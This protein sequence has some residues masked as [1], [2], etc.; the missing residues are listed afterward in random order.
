MNN[1]TKYRA[2]PECCVDPMC[3]S[4]LRNNYFEGKRL[5]V[6]SFRVEQKYLLERRQLLNRAI[7]GWG[8][9]YGFAI[10]AGSPDKDPGPG[11]LKIGAGLAL[12]QCGR[13]LLQTE[14]P[15]EVTDLIIF[16]ENGKRIDLE[17]A[18]SMSGPYDRQAANHW[19]PM[20]WLLSVHYAEQYTAPVRV[21][22]PCRCKRD[23]WNHTC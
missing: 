2:H 10:T 8:V 16:D 14:T 13:E 23:E 12:D 21:E 22:D 9:V 7:H 19:P 11:R 1:P 15:I 6:D 17:T 3:E 4:G 5:T 18:L 20:C